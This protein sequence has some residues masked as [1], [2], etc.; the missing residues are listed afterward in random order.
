[1][2]QGGGAAA[3]PAPAP[4]GARSSSKFPRGH[5]QYTLQQHNISPEPNKVSQSPST[6][7]GRQEQPLAY[8]HQAQAQLLVT[9]TATTSSSNSRQLRCENSL[10]QLQLID[11]H[12]HRQ[13]RG[14]A[15]VVANAEQCDN[16]AAPLRGGTNRETPTAASAAPIEEAKADGLL[17]LPSSSSARPARGGVLPQTEVEP[18]H[19]DGATSSSTR[20]SINRSMPSSPRATGYS[21]QGSPALPAA[22][23]AADAGAGGGGGGDGRGNSSNR[24]GGAHGNAGGASPVVGAPKAH[25]DL[26]ATPNDGSGSSPKEPMIAR[27]ELH[28]VAQGGGGG[29]NVDGD[30]DAGGERG[31]FSSRRSRPRSPAAGNFHG[32][33]RAPDSGRSVPSPATASSPFSGGVGS[34]KR[35]KKVG[36]AGDAAS[37][38]DRSGAMGV[39]RAS[40]PPPLSTATSRQRKYFTVESST[41][42]AVRA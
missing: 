24:D 8:P 11:G 32:D 9:T 22:A 34:R 28:A 35:P 10:R 26:A 3:A 38:T 15:E 30:D 1:M 41:P 27:S 37:T 18:P 16:F 19:E 31:G 36:A 29:G 23:S 14:D 25:V 2:C 39:V 5:H 33:D 17:L 4:A 40:S 13:Q 6:A 12:N 21:H 7:P 42:D 20:L